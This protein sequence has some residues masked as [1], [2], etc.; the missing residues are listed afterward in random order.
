MRQQN[1]DL[2]EEYDRLSAEP[3][4]EVAEIT[5]AVIARATELRVQYGFKTAD[6]IHL[7]TAI[8]HSATAVLTGDEHFRR[9]QEVRVEIVP[10]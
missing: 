4:F 3:A 6:A 1:A 7:A 5:A 8:E 2:L 9:C 10:R